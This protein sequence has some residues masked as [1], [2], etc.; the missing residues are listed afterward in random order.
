[1][2]IEQSWMVKNLIGLVIVL[3]MTACTNAPVSNDYGPK[4]NQNKKLLVAQYLIGVDDKVQVDVWKHPDLTVNVPVRPDGMISVPLIGEVL[5][6]GKTPKNVAAE[7]QKRLSKYI[8]QPNV[9]V[10]LMELRSHEYLSRVRITGSVRTPLSLTYRQG[11]TVLD[12]VLTAGGLNDF[13]SGNNTKLFRRIDGKVQ[14]IN[15]KLDDIFSN[16]E[17]E[18][19]YAM[20]PGDILS[21]PERTF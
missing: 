7:I 15:I 2:K 14:A 12:V 6:G 5:A 10:I 18:T 17:M 16:G 11:M 13:A 20:E 21:I 19:N 1:M 8:K 4:P 3:I 9:A